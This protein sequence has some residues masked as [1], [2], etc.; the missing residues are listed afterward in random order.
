MFSSR[1]CEWFALLLAGT[2]APASESLAAEPAACAAPA[3]QSADAAACELA[4][5]L[6]RQ[7]I[8]PEQG[9]RYAAVLREGV[10]AGRYAALDKAAAAEAMTHDLQ[11]TAPDGHLSVRLREPDK[12]GGGSQAEAKAPFPILEEADWIA[13]GIAYMRINEFPYDPAITAR[14][15]QFMADHADARALIFDLR[16]H[17]GGGV[18]QMDAILP[19][20]FAEPTRLVTM[21]TS[22]DVERELG[23]PV[24]DVASM[25]LLGDT[26]MARREH[27]VTPNAD[28]RLRD[29]RVY[30]LTSGRTASAAEHFALALKRT[31]RATLVGAATAGANH[32]GGQADLP[33]G[34]F[35]FI[36]V[37][38]TFDPDT[39]E[40]WEGDGVAPDIAVAPE[41]ALERALTELGFA[42]EEA[43]RL[44]DAHKPT[45]TME[46]RKR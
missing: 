17:H 1:Y 9:A 46:R 25:T 35:A 42:P 5:L 32:F 19:W 41:L 38:R 37:G 23:S 8:Y 21:E 33:G 27:W 28:T 3:D 22:W 13:P 2:L 10:A 11:T 16:T 36:P 40:D 18:E 30:L 29:A 4:A 26:A 44:S 34:F 31:G 39:G 14:V 20:L 7:F 24:A 45:L 12:P 43:K 6:E 15:A